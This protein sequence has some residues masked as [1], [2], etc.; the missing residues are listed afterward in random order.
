[1]RV[2]F[3]HFLV[4]GG[5]G[6]SIVVELERSVLIQFVKS[7]GE[8]L[9]DFAR[10]VLVRAGVQHRVR[11]VVMHHVEVI[12]HGWVKGDVLEQLSKIAEGILGQ[13]IP[14]GRHAFRMIIHGVAVAGDDHELTQREGDALAQLVRRIDHGV[15]PRLLELVVTR[16]GIGR[17]GRDRLINSRQ[18]RCGRGVELLAQEIDEALLLQLRQER[19]G[20]AEGRL[21]QKTRAVDLR[22]RSGGQRHGG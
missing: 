3:D 19:V 4:V 20:R 14:V 7:D 21:S 16:I 22:D 2:T 5:D 9:H 13:Q 15:P 18:R 17:Q 1:M 12:A 6:L 10:V 11:L 8:Q